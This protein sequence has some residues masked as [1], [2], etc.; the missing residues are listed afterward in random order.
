MEWHGIGKARTERLRWPVVLAWALTMGLHGA[1]LCWLTRDAA[2]DRRTAGE[3]VSTNDRLILQL[4]SRPPMARPPMKQR[5]PNKPGE[6]VRPKAALAQAPAPARAAA[7]SSSAPSAARAPVG[8]SSPAPPQLYN[9]D[10]SIRWSA[11]APGAAVR[12][13]NV[14][15][16][17][18][19]QQLPCHDTRFAHAYARAQDETAGA[20]FARKY[21]SWIGLYNPHTEAAYQQRRA[22]HDRACAP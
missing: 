18:H 14:A 2:P 4:L 9:T 20:G 1:A 12:A 6:L 7:L 19:F 10:G 17:R 21:L 15:D 11:A 13:G 5:T 3:A 16:M 22:W 8:T